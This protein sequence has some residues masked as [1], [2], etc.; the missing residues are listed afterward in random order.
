MVARGL[1]TLDEAAVYFGVW[2]VSLRRWTTSGQ[3]KCDRVGCS[4]SEELKRCRPIL[5]GSL[6][7]LFEN[8]Q[9]KVVP[10]QTLR[11]CVVGRQILDPVVTPRPRA[12]GSV[13]SLPESVRPGS[14]AHGRLR[15]S[16]RCACLN[17]VVHA[18]ST[19]W[20][21]EVREV[22]R[23]F[24]FKRHALAAGGVIERK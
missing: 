20:I 18:E 7:N 17:A 9:V 16:R 24:G 2:K 5:V 15:V 21:Y 13:P 1:M 12:R 3:L 19:L 22:F 23:D 8:V 14:G 11:V 6:K 4:V 10:L